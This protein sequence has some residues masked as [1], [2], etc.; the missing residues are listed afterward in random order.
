M[1]TLS[2]ETQS[3]EYKDSI[4]NPTWGRIQTWSNQNL[5]TQLWI[6]VLWKS[7]TMF[8]P[9]VWGGSVPQKKGNMERHEGE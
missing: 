4:Y 9:I 8:G 3:V 6:W 1:F 5:L 7:K 2:L